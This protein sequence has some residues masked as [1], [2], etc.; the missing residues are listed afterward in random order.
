MMASLPSRGRV[1][2]ATGCGGL[3]GLLV[4]FRDGIWTGECAVYCFYKGGVARSLYTR[5][6]G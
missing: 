5:R 3:E 4:R 1:M 2:A 6:N